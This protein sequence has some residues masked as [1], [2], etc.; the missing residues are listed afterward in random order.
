[1]KNHEKH[2]GKE[3]FIYIFYDLTVKTFKMGRT[4]NPTKFRL[5]TIISNSAT[6]N[7]ELRYVFALENYFFVER[8]LKLKF[9]H[10]MKHGTRDFGEWFDFKEEDLKE[11]IQ[12]VTRWKKGEIGI[13]L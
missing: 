11:I 13:N 2:I 1:M 8:N 4:M 3:G 12:Y 6:G 10:R 9:A 7:I 5:S